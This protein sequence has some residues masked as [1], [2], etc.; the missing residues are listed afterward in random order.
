MLNTC[1]DVCSVSCTLSYLL[2]IH[3]AIDSAKRKMAVLVLQ[4]TLHKSQCIRMPRKN[5]YQRKAVS[6]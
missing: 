5:T 4:E 2:D 3:D 1:T 6:M